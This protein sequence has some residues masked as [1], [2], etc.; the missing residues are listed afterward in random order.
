MTVDHTLDSIIWLHGSWAKTYNLQQLGIVP[1]KATG[2]EVTPLNGSGVSIEQHTL[3]LPMGQL[4]KLGI[5]GMLIPKLQPGATNF[6]QFLAANVNC[7]MVGNSIAQLAGLG[8]G[9]TWATYCD[10]AVAAAAK[11]V[12]DKLDDIDSAGA[13]LDISGQG[14]L[15][16]TNSDGTYEAIQNGL[17]SGSFTINS[18]TAVISGTQSQFSSIAH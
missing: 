18:A 16:D 6:Q 13:K 3:D 14:T 11:V 8:S 9:S 15:V 1:P 17:W 2:V 10:L 12:D 5:N 4:L 7:Q